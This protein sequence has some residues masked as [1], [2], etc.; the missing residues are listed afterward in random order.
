MDSLY[1]DELNLDTASKMDHADENE[2]LL[3]Q[4]CQ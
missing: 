2:E 4:A 1:K 3:S